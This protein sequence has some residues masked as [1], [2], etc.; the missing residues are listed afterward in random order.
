MQMNLPALS[1]KH[2]DSDMAGFRGRILR[3]ND[4]LFYKIVRFI[5]VYSTKDALAGAQAIAPALPAT[6]ASPE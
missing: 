3:Q 6:P 1:Q 5:T 2:D 4:D